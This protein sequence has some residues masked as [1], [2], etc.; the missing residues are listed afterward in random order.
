ML[1]VPRPAQS[2]PRV[3][4]EQAAQRPIS[5]KAVGSNSPRGLPAVPP[6]GPP[7]AVRGQ[8]LAGPEPLGR[9]CPRIAP[10]EL[11]TAA[12]G[13]ATVTN[14]ATKFAISM[15]TNNPGNFW[16]E[17]PG[18]TAL[19]ITRPFA[20]ADWGSVGTWCGYSGEP[21]PTATAID[22]YYSDDQVYYGDQP[23]ATT[24]EYAEQAEEIAT[25]GQRRPRKATGCPWEFLR[26]HRMARPP[27]QS[28]HSTC[29]LP[30]VS[31]A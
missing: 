19:A 17:N 6:S 20:W 23:V 4:R 11:K 7:L 27:A 25:T 14:G 26:S 15:S 21:A 10:S 8:T 30:S 22:I 9:I 12:S 29:S 13:K 31:R 18:W 3:R 28:H 24:E 2:G 16:Q 1:R 5:C